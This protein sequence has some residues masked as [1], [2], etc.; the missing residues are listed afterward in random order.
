MRTIAATALIVELPRYFMEPGLRIILRI[1][2]RCSSSAEICSRQ[3]SSSMMLLPC[4]QCFS[5]LRYS[6]R[7]SSSCDQRFGEDLVDVVLVRFQQR[8]DLERRMPAEIRDVLAR[9]GRVRLGLFRL[10][11]QPAD[12]RDAVVAEDHEAVVQVANQPRE[13][14]LENVIEGRDDL[15]IFRSGRKARS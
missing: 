1:S 4:N 2:A 11:A 9:L 7:P 6:S 3:Y 8:A 5:S 13:L 14:E 12:D 15:F 10:I